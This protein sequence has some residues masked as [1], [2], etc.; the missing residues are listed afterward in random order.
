TA[1]CGSLPFAAGGAA[2]QPK[3][4]L[5]AAIVTAYEKGLHADVLIGK[6]LE[7]WQQ[8]GGARPALKLAAMYVEQFT[9]KDLS[10]ALAKKHDVP[11]FDTIE[12]A[13]TVGGNRIPVDGVISVG[14]H[15]DYPY[16]DL[17]QHLYPRRRFFE[18]ITDAFRK[19]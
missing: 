6:I 14:E 19:Y 3:P 15:G 4:K 11:I 16:N 18:A 13:V 10:R 7:G 2:E 5:V 12:K 1:L 8:D 17:G 9:A